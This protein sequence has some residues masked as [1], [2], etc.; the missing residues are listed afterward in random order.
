[1]RTCVSS[2]DDAS[3][4][5]TIEKAREVIAESM[6]SSECPSVEKNEDTT[7]ELPLNRDLLVELSEAQN[8]VEEARDLLMDVQKEIRTPH[9]SI[10]SKKLSVDPESS[11]ND[12]SAPMKLSPPIPAIPTQCSP[13]FKSSPIEPSRHEDVVSYHRTISFS[14]VRILLCEVPVVFE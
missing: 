6:M 4:L 1:M 3:C 14:P 9:V 12:S 8:I 13:S 2:S 11:L 7:K 5:E 10:S